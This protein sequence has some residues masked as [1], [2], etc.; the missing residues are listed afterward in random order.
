MNGAQNRH[1]AAVRR[2]QAEAKDHEEKANAKFQRSQDDHADEMRKIRQEIKVQDDEYR[3]M[4]ENMQKKFD[5]TIKNM[6][7]D[8][9]SQFR[10]QDNKHTS[11][12]Q[13]RI[14]LYTSLE[15]T[16]TIEIKT[17]IEEHSRILTELRS[18]MEEMRSSYEIRI[19]AMTITIE[20]KV[21]TILMKDS[22]ILSLEQVLE[23]KKDVETQREEAIAREHTGMRAR[24]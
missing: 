4:I 7:F 2:M 8:F 16:K 22:T 17:I 10:N 18:K 9:S 11:E 12:I 5:E 15:A 23:K 20:Q 1:E 3:L 13:E 19:D 6:N 21:Q 14:R 24:E